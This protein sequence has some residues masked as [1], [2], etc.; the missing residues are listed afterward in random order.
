MDAFIV[1]VI[2]VVFITLM[3]GGGQSSAEPPPIQIVYVPAESAESVGR[4][5]GFLPGVVIGAAL[6]FLVHLFVT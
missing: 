2:L 6:L 3:A 4:R 5:L 1:A